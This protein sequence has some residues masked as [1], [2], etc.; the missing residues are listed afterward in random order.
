LARWR[1]NNVQPSAYPLDYMSNT[2]GPTTDGGD[3]WSEW[4][5]DEG[6]EDSVY[7][8]VR[9]AVSNTDDPTMPVNT[10]RMW[11]LGLAGSVLLAGVN[12]VRCLRQASVR[13]YLARAPPSAAEPT[14][15]SAVL[16]LPLPVSHGL[17]ARHPTRDVPDGSLYGTHPSRRP[18]VHQPRLAPCPAV[19][20]SRAKLTICLP[21]VCQALSTSRCAGRLFERLEG[22]ADRENDISRSTR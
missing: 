1:D 15:L 17:V 10:L 2:E 21:P 20:L 8:E 22:R 9:A 3:V 4:G 18:L 14:A 11:L 6:E 5:F 13:A 19:E 7:A 16:L 12:Q